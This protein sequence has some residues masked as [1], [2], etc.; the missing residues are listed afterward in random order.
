MVS[1]VIAAH[2]EQNVLGGCLDALISQGVDACD[3]VVSANGCTDRTA[4]VAASRGVVVIDRTTPGKAAALNAA[5]AVAKGFPRIYLDAD[6]VLPPGAI[7]AAVAHIS[8]H[9]RRP[10]A[11]PSR[12]VNTRERAWPVRG[13]YAINERL[14]VFRNSLFGRGMFVLSEEGRSR[15]GEFPELVADDLFVDSQF[16]DDEKQSIDGVEVLV[17]VPYTTALLIKRLVRVRRGNAEVR[18]A[19]SSGEVTGNARA[20]SQSSWLRDV[21]LRDPR[22]V[23]AA[24]PFVVITL[25]A[26]VL[27]RRTSSATSDS[28]GRD[29]STRA[30]TTPSGLPEAA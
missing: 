14:P 9:A 12:R 26:A 7:D 11:A 8:G 22:L 15:F 2:N 16:S 5:D 24:I 23:F 18:A 29:D 13:Y 21:V 30:Q 20:S 28:W 27:A 19:T 6:I 4:E 25:T 1:V 17:E 10:A 3:I